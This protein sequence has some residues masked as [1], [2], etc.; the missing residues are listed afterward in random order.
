MAPS[1]FC[2]KQKLTPGVAVPMELARCRECG[3]LIS[4]KSH[5][6]AESV[7]RAVD[8]EGVVLP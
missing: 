7:T 2:P 5:Q 3:D 4:E 1:P 6:L 8:V